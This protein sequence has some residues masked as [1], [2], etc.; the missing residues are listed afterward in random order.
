MSPN[1][2]SYSIITLIVGLVT[3]AAVMA[4]TM[5]LA[6]RMEKLTVVDTAWGLGFVV[7]ALLVVF[8]VVR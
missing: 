5:W 4:V 1:D 7:V 8:L 2:F 6:V 3:V